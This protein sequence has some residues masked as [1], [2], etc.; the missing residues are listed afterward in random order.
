MVR[1][2]PGSQERVLGTVK[3][4]IMGLSDDAYEFVRRNKQLLIAKFADPKDYST[5]RKPITIFMA[6]SPGA[7][8]T[9]FSKSFVQMQSA[10]NFKK[11]RKK[12]TTKKLFISAWLQPRV[13]CLG[14]WPAKSLQNGNDWIWV[15]VKDENIESDL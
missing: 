2:H 4:K 14:I 1:V 8:K 3:R 7:G 11:L 10:P 6:G 9:E 15:D 5:S 12:M 13:V